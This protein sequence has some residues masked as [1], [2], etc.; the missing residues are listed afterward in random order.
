MLQQDYIPVLV[1]GGGLAGLTVALR[2]ADSGV[3]VGLLAKRSLDDGS[4]Y[5]AQGGI[6]AVLGEDD[7]I[8]SHIEA[9]SYT[10]LTLTTILL[11]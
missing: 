7:S 10:H 5:H 6:A 2:L 8:E 9:V 4:S 3:H 11:V 1:L